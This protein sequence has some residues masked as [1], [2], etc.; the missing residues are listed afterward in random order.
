[1]TEPNRPELRP[2]PMAHESPLTADEQSVVDMLAAA[3]T[4]AMPLDVWTRISAALSIEAANRQA[5]EKF[6]LPHFVIE[7]QS[8]ISEHTKL[9]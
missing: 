1:M 2:T 3:P 9:I 6:D 8:Q 7:K 5:T 4:P